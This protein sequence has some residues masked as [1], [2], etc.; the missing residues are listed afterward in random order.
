MS[1][2]S[3]VQALARSLPAEH[4]ADAVELLDER[5]LAK[6]ELLARDLRLLAAD[7]DATPVETDA[8]EAVAAERL[9]RGATALRELDALRH[10]RVDPLNAEVKRVNALFKLVTDP[11]LEL[12][13][14]GGSVE[15]QLL[16]YRQVRRARHERERLEA[17]RRQ[18]EAAV[19]EAQ[20]LERAKAAADPEA[21]RAALAE[22]DAASRAQA[23]ATLDAPRQLTRG[24]RTD[25]GTVSVRERWVF[26]VVDPA[27]L[28]REYLVPDEKAL[29]AAVAAGVRSIPGVS[30]HLEESLT[31]RIG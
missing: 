27:L 8:E 12:V 25:S 22:A 24:V 16:A 9:S 23:L 28:P 11:A 31:R 20:A 14:K 29:R 5:G 1:E 13:G 2:D 10:S 18:E 15:R 17:Q 19:A 21:R 7:V 4:V 30:I 26:E 3:I 6:L